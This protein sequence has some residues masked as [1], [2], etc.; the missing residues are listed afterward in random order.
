MSTISSSSSSAGTSRGSRGFVGPRRGKR[1]TGK[2]PSEIQRYLIVLF[3][4]EPIFTIRLG[5]PSSIVPCSR[6]GRGI[7]R[8]L[9]SHLISRD[10]KRYI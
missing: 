8:C 3:I 7:H 1:F 4:V 9:G 10:D 6:K 5:F 2:D